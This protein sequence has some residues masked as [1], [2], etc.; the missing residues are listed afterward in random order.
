MSKAEL[1]SNTRI[2]GDY[3]RA[4]FAAPEAA[5]GA[6]AGQF[7][8]LRIDRRADR[9]LRRPF[10]IFNAENGRVTIIYKVIGAGT[11]HLA[12]LTPGAVCDML[13]PC[14]KGFSAPAPDVL[15]VALCGGFGAAATYMLTRYGKGVLLL[16][17]RT[18]DDL[19]L[20]R[21]YADAGYEVR[22]ATDD[23]SAGVKGKVTDLIAPLAA[24]HPD[25]RLFIYACGPNPMLMAL[26][27]L[28]R[29]KGWDGELSVDQF[30]CCG[31]GACFGCVVKVNDPAHPGEWMYAR[32]CVDGPIFRL[33]DVYTE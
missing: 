3:F 23:G 18:R 30:M 19:L 25:R 1:I 15:P 6:V 32:S 2:Q 27:K 8:H 14:G 17:A 13:G 20:T 29:A 5:A 12:A 7:V 22:I 9:I 28:M 16:G 10:S 26:A 4:V 24:E 21:E 11:A 33:A 31:V